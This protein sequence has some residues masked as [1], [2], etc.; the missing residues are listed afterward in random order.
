M[1][2]LNKFET[3]IIALM[4]LLIFVFVFFE[5]VV[6]KVEEQNKRITESFKYGSLIQP[7]NCHWI[8][9]KV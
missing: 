2:K 5:I 8:L 3:I 6:P 7:Q 1:R 9:P 4:F